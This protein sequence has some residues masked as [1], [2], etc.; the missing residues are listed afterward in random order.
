M[1]R[2]AE[3]VKTR[4]RVML[5]EATIEAKVKVAHERALQ[6]EERVVIVERD[7]ANG[8]AYA[9]LDGYDELQE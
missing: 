3:L 8:L 2:E 9:F 7:L 6:A 1:L 5:R 4:E